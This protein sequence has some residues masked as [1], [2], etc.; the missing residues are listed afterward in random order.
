QFKLFRTA[1]SHIRADS[2]EV[3]RRPLY[4]SP[5]TDQP[6][7]IQKNHRIASEQTLRQCAGVIAIHHPCIAIEEWFDSRGPFRFRW[8]NPAWLPVQRVQMNDIDAKQGTE[9][10]GKCTLASAAGTDYQYFF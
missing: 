3:D 6:M 5:Q 7:A 2:A 9:A 4:Y 1:R 10:P 8:L